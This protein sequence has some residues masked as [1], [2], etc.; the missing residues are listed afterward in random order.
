MKKQAKK[1]IDGL[2]KIPL[3]MEITLQLHLVAFED[4]ILINL[5]HSSRLY[6]QLMFVFPDPQPSLVSSR[7][8]SRELS[9]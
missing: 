4:Q 3:M 5:S 1:W 7:L 8:I 2:W 6:T 9:I